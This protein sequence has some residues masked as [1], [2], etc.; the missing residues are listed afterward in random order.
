MKTL[1]IKSGEYTIEVKTEGEG[2]LILCVHGWPES[3]YSWRH[4]M[5]HF[6]PKGYQVAAM[7]V[8]GYG[9]SSHPVGIEDYTL[10]ALSDDIA[11][12]ARALSPRPA[13]LFGHDWGAPQV[14]T[15]ALRFPELFSAVAGLSVPFSPPSDSSMLD[16]WGLAYQGRFFY[17]T[18]FQKPGAVEAELS[19]DVGLALRKIYFA[20]SGEAPL[21]EWIKAKPQDAGLLDGLIDPEPFPDWMTIDDFAVYVDAFEKAGFV[22]PIHRYRAVSFDAVLLPELNGR[23]LS[24]PSCFIGGSRDAVRSFI[25]GMDLYN[26]PGANC[27]DFFESTLIEGAGHWVQQEAPAETNLALERFLK[28]L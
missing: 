22:G 19:E 26:D 16:L 5:S 21:N 24:Q 3:W 27:D 25:P 14:Y 10:Q 23:S 18:Y 20:L 11:A 7:S 12:V 6:A 13:I 2:P 8:R 28:N 4:Q 15:A 17:Q 9:N 1:E